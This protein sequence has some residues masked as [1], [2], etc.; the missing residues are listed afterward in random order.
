MVV[1]AMQPILGA[2]SRQIRPGIASRTRAQ[3]RQAIVQIF[4]FYSPILVRCGSY[5][6]PTSATTRCNAKGAAKTSPLP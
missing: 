2:I 1:L 6:N 4:A 5:P 3:P